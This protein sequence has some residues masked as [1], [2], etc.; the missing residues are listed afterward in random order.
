MPLRHQVKMFSGPLGIWVYGA[1]KLYKYEA[2]RHLLHWR[3]DVTEYFVGWQYLLD[4]RAYPWERDGPTGVIHH[5]FFPYN[6]YFESPTHGVA[7]LTTVR[8][9][10][11]SPELFKWGWGAWVV[12]GNIMGKYMLFNVFCIHNYP[13]DTL[14]LSL[15]LSPQ[16]ARLQWDVTHAAHM[17][18]SSIATYFDFSLSYLRDKNYSTASYMVCSTGI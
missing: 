16:K 6:F 14:F 15:D 18:P 12:P 7:H 8:N 4:F 17:I 5:T 3:K 13:Q 9:L 2:I 10:A 1:V 11:I